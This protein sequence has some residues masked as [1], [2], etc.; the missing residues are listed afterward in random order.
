MIQLF[1]DG[2]D[3]NGIMKAAED[4]RISGFTT[5]PTLMRQAGVTNYTEFAKNIIS[6]LSEKRPETCLS[7]EV[8]AD[9]FEEMYSQALK[10]DSWGRERSYDVYVKIPVTNTEG[11]S[12]AQ[13]VKRLVDSRVKVNV[14]AVFTIEQTINTLVNLNK[15]VK[16]IISIFAGRI[17]DTGVDPVPLMKE[18]VRINDGLSQILWASPREVLNYVHAKCCLCDIITMTPDLI[19]KMDNF[20]KDHNE[21]SLDTVKMFYN[22]ATK[23]GYSI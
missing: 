1:A 10:I 5:N 12:S 13:L 14:T 17:A 2:A 7:L 9:D 4:Q 20:G 21:F 3:T 15:D 11:K 22:D 23:S 18:I 19:K 6:A 8:F 16:S